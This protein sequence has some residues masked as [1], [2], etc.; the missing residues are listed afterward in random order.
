MFLEPFCQGSLCLPDVRC[1]TVCTF[2]GEHQTCLFFH[3][4]REP[5][6][7]S[8]QTGSAGV[9]AGADVSHYASTVEKS[10][11]LVGNLANIWDDDTPFA[12]GSRV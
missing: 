1:R 8:Y 10:S 4:I 9:F 5:V 7:R 6:F 2:D 3:Y 12:G 11:Y